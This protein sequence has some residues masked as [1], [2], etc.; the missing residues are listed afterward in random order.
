MATFRKGVR[1]IQLVGRASESLM[2]L[3]SFLIKKLTMHIVHFLP[4]ELSIH[5][6]RNQQCSIQT[7]TTTHVLFL[8]STQKNTSLEPQKLSISVFL[9]II[10]PFESN[11][12]H[13]KHI[14]LITQ[15]K[16]KECFLIN[17]RIQRM[18]CPL[19]ANAGPL[20]V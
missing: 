9:Y 2:F 7:N 20:H 12:C 13:S 5:K 6:E 10:Y 8:L 15:C 4:K 16:G 19:L 3:L 11:F 17:P 18:Q 14:V 1:A